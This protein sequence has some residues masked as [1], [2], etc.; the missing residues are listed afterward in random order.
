M[1]IKIFARAR[2]R[3][4]AAAYNKNAVRL[5]MRERERE[6]K[7]AGIKCAPCENQQRA[8]HSPAERNSR[9]NARALDD[10]WILFAEKFSFWF[11][12]LGALGIIWLSGGVGAQPTQ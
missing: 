11:L 12:S 5:V 3:N 9:D 6:K 8:L 4:E 7:S 10:N 2:R 1:Q